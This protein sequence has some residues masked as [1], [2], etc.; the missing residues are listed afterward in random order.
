MK[1][2]KLPQWAAIAEII[3]TI[4]VIVSLVFVGISINRSTDETRANQTNVLYETARQIELVVAAD[5]EWSR[6]VVQGRS[7]VREFNDVEQYRYEA[8]LIAVLDLWDETLDRYE[9]GL[10]SVNM[11]EGWEFYF[12]EWTKRYVTD[13]DWQRIKWSYGS[14]R[15]DRVPSILSDKR[16]D[17]S[18][19]AE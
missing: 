9:D 14:G 17:I 1:Q 12:T 8:Y 19:K 11:V 6:I 10:I 15:M 5:P 2:L 7:G 16:H 18:K 3:G 4:A 13:Y